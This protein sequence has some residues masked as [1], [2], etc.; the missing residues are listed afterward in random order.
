MDFLSL[1][2]NA[3][4]Q[5]L[6]LSAALLLD[7]ENFPLR[8]DLA[9]HLKSHCRYPVTLKFAVANWQNISVAKLDKHLHQQGYQLL[10]VPQG[11][12]AAD[13]QIL[14]LGAS[15]KL[16]YPQV[17]E[18]VIVSRDT[19]F[20]YLHQTLQRQDCHTYQVY[21]QSGK[22]YVNDFTNDRHLLM[23][24]IDQGNPN[25]AQTV[26]QKIQTKIE[27]TLAELIKQSTDKVTLAQLSQEFKRKYQHSISETLKQNKLPKSTLNF[28]KKSCTNKIKVEVNSSNKQYYLVLKST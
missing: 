23:T 12:N 27:L 7:V 14:S 2:R 11:K 10:H 6:S 8:L 17:K 24:Q 20:N 5:A 25:S 26:V 16:T 4:A 9:Q 21:Q 28:I 22:I 18:V 3:S 15:L 1:P 13:A 19:I